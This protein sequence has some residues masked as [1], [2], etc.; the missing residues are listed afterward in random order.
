MDPEFEDIQIQLSRIWRLYHRRIY[1]VLILLVLLWASSSVCYKVGP[2]S[3]GVVLRMG[4]FSKS[5]PPGLQFKLPWPIDAVYTVPVKRVQSIEFGYRTEEPGRV[6]RYARQTAEQQTLARMLTADLNL[7]HVEWV[8]QY[9]VRD[10]RK[11]LFKI[12]G[13]PNADADVNA[14]LL[15]HNVSEAVMRRIIGDVSVDSVITTGREQI[16]ADAKLEMQQMLDGYESGIE[17]V[18]VKLQSATPPEKV[19]DAFD[20]VNRAKQMKEKVVNDAKGERNR[21]IPEAR[22]KRDRT[23]AEAEGY[24][25]RRTKKATGQAT[26]FLAQLV[27]YEKAPEVTKTRLYIETLEAVLREV[28]DKIIIDE[29]VEGMLPIL[30]LNRSADGEEGGVR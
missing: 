16:G 20:A 28:N 14:R 6:T 13:D 8:V 25:L 5:T 26:A 18:N 21:L 22:G 19:K 30:N 15:I 10:A 24:E 27:E 4:E 17:V 1:A 11:Y 3:E 9:R 12:G 23:I 29:S 2:Y 7:A